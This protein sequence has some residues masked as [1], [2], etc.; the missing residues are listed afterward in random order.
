MSD[1][2]RGRR[3]G[4]GRAER[5]EV[6]SEELGWIADLRQAREAGGD[7]GPDGDDDEAPAPARPSRRATFDGLRGDD[8]PESPAPAVEPPGLAPF[9]A[10]PGRPGGLRAEP[11]M[12]DPLRV[13]PARGV[14]P[15]TEPTGAETAGRSGGS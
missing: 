14:D 15:R 2:D 1:P 7:L 6:P 13:E 4:R 8:P 9:A 11:T 12:V 3:K 10:D 5:D